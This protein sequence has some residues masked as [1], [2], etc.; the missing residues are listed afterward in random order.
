VADLV[1]MLSQ[2]EA[3]YGSLMGEP[4]VVVEEIDGTVLVE[5]LALKHWQTPGY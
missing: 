1:E 3:V 5:R 4:L 2:W